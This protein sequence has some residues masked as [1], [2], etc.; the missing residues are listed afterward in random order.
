[1]W[2]FRVPLHY[3]FNQ[4]NDFGNILRGKDWKINPKN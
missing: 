1:M 2:L 3:T 4:Y